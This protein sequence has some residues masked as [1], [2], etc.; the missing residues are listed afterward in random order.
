MQIITL[1][2]ELIHGLDCLKNSL[3]KNDLTMPYTLYLYRF[4][5]GYYILDGI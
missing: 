5:I 4:T 3:N 1:V 2:I